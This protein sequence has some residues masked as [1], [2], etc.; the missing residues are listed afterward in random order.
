LSI[1]AAFFGSLSRDAEV[2]TSKGGKRYLRLN[3]RVGDGDASQWVSVMAFDERALDQADKL[4]KGSRVYVEG[5]IKLDEWTGADGVQ[6]HGLSRMSW[7]CRIAE[8]GR[9]KPKRE[10]EPVPEKAQ[11]AAASNDFHSYEVPF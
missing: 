9:N 6:R 7:Y 5:S 10:R 11:A 3:V 8:I 2:K 4:T 1:E